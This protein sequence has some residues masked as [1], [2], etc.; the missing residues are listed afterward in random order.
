MNSS[1][2]VAAV[3][4]WVRRLVRSDQ[5]D[6]PLTVVGAVAHRV[7]WAMG[8]DPVD[9][10][11]ATGRSTVDLGEPPPGGWINPWLVGAVHEQ[12][13][14]TGERQARGAWYTPEPVVRGLVALATADGVPPQTAV[15]PTCGGG[16]FLLAV[17]DRLVELG[18]SPTDALGR[19]AGL[20]VDSGAVEVARWSLL[21][22]AGSHHI[23]PALAD[24]AI[25]VT[26]GDAL[27]ATPDRWSSRRLVV[28][29]PPFASPLRAGAI[30]KPAAA[31]RH[32]NSELLGPY[33]DLAAIH[34]LQAVACCDHGSTVAMV[35]PQSV[36]AGRDTAGLRRHFD[37]FGAAPI[38]S[39]WAARES[40]FDAG[41]RACA[42]VVRP[43]GTPSGSVT[44][45]AGVDVSPAGCTSPATW[46]ELAAIALGRPALPAELTTVDDRPVGGNFVVGHPTERLA[47]LANATAGFRDEHYG[48]AAA[49]REWS[50]DPA[51]APNRLTTVGMVDPLFSAWGHGQ[52]RFGGK[53]WTMPV[54]DTAALQGKV[55]RWTDRQLRPKVVLATQ[56]KVLEPV[57]DRI[58]NIV[59]ATPLIAVHGRPEDL[60]HIAAVLLS[61][62]VVAWAWTR[63][64]GTAMAVD[65]LKLSATQ[66]GELPLPS[67][68]AA[69]DRAADLI[70]RWTEDDA[71]VGANRDGMACAIEV[72]AIMN[73]SYGGSAELLAWWTNR[74]LGRGGKTNPRSNQPAR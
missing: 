31:I 24:A 54:I 69:W 52:F 38:Q 51:D 58:G 65:A 63:W 1:P 74:A 35:Q 7:A 25:D 2:P 47:S 8:V 16:A 17:L 34:L 55:A 28:G 15:D 41:V 5:V 39:M 59:P 4:N 57:I 11:V 23:P 50:G 56:S 21:L 22:W 46:S 66:V 37:E 12:V 71:A 9:Y 62:P 10:G 18:V 27:L 44:L 14:S 72:A 61:P 3:R 60:A 64:F 42:V 26:V 70:A 29:N 32:Q 40:V 45:R 30:P 19:V 48:L 49:C 33:A 43:G 53:R 68:R 6:D 36:L 13:V 20:D 73:D 67:D